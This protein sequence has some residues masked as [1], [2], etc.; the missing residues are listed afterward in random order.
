[1]A[2]L[3]CSRL[4]WANLKAQSVGECVPARGSGLVHS[5]FARACNIELQ[6][7][8][9]VSLLAAGLGAT[10]HGIRLQAQPAPFDTWLRQGERAILH[11]A[12][13]RLPDAG[14]AVDLS[15]AARWQGAVAAVCVQDR[16]TACR[17]RALRAVL[18]ERAPRQGV[19][20]ALLPGANAMTSLEQAL[21]SRLSQLLPTLAQATRDRDLVAM[22]VSAQRL[23]GLGPGLTPAGDDFLAGWL[24]ALW[25]QAALDSDLLTLLRPFGTALAPAVRRVHAISRQMLD[26]AARGCF[27]QILVEVTLALAGEGDLGQAAAGAL[28]HGHSS[29]ADALCGLLF[30]YEPASL[31]CADEWHAARA[32]RSPTGSSASFF[33]S[34]SH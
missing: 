23:V 30:G 4:L 15:A 6:G 19:A 16:A 5:V 8:T 1:M 9:L 29:G 31:P 10:P 32:V 34:G 28:A 25:S 27:S 3:E 7:G 20:L 14:V 11:Q 17:L 18:C 22:A 26:E 24:A 13:L 33:L 12:M 2:E 21:A